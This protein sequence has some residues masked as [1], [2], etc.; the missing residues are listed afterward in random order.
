MTREAGHT[1]F[2]AGV[3]RIFRHTSTNK[4]TYANSAA[5]IDSAEIKLNTR[6]PSAQAT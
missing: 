2:K 3:G 4:S 1:G 5:D 6:D